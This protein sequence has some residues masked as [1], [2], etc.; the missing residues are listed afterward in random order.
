MW[1]EIARHAPGFDSAVLTGVAED[2]YPFSARC[3]PEIDMAA[4]VLRIRGPLPAGIVAGPAGLLYHRHD[5]RLGGLKSFLLRGTL[6]RAG[7]GWEFRP[8]RYVPGVG[9]QGLWGYVRFVVDGRRNT[10]RYLEQ[11]GWPWPRLP[12]EQ[13]LSSLGPER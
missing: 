4:Q 6:L 8:M 2:G 5:A 12:L 1:A 7:D 11:R 3:R 9:V 10:R 13:L